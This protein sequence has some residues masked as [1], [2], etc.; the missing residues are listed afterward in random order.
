MANT[1]STDVPTKDAPKKIACRHSP[2]L[3]SLSEKGANRVCIHCGEEVYMTLKDGRI[4]LKPDW[5]T[6]S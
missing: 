3:G 4:V 5:A 1:I 6:G 2:H